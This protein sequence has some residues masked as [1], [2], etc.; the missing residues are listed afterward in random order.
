MYT[1]YTFSIHC[2]YIYGYMYTIVYALSHTYTT[3]I[4]MPLQ[5]WGRSLDC[6]DHLATMHAT[7]FPIIFF[8]LRQSLPRCRGVHFV[9]AMTFTWSTWF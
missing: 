5:S 4:Q 9:M 7:Q 1:M 2:V 6:Q 8:A 3:N